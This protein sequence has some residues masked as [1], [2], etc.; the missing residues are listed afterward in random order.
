MGV[1]EINIPANLLGFVGI[2]DTINHRLFVV[3][4]IHKRGSLIRQMQIN[5]IAA[6]N[7][8]PRK[9]VKAGLAKDRAGANIGGAAL[10]IQRCRC[11]PIGDNLGLAIG[12]RKRRKNDLQ[13]CCKQRCRPKYL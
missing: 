6:V 11:P 9:R 7:I 1:Q 10:N 4:H 3:N 2:Q 5:R 12:E 8:K 13:R